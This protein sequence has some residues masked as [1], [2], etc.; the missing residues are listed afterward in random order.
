M[1]WS[2]PTIG[3]WAVINPPSSNLAA[4]L[5]LASLGW[6][7]FPCIETPGEKSKSPYTKNGFHDATTDPTQIKIWWDYK[8]DA[9]IGFAI[10]EHLLVI[11]IDPHNG[12][13]REALESKTGP[14]PQTLTA[15]SGRGNG[16]HHLYFFSPGGD[17]TSTKLGVGIDLRAG[18]RHYVIVPP[19]IHPDSGLPYRWENWDGP[20]AVPPY[21]LTE[22][23]RLD[24]SGVRKFVINPD[25]DYSQLLN[26][27]AETPS[28]S[29]NDHTFFAACRLA[30]K[31]AL[32]SHEEALVGAA[33]ASGLG[34]REVRTC[35]MSAR[36]RI[37]T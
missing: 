13:S 25:D 28:G 5:E 32:D 18:G 17:L 14:L 36:R 26:W 3:G 4:A 11:D 1:T 23:L 16:G 21:Q 7:V 15:W 24:L 30:E 27:V 2:A 12:G 22:L 9:L 33:M 19:S 29:R 35:I 6:H 34:E 37:N 8:P 10:P 20:I 31:G